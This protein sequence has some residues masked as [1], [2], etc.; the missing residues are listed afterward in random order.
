MDDYSA[1]ETIGFSAQLAAIYTE[2]SRYSSLFCRARFGLS[3]TEYE[4]LLCLWEAETPLGFNQLSDFLMLKTST[5]W[6]MVPPLI[7]RSLLAAE[8]SDED[9]RRARL[10]LTEKGRLLAE[11]CCRDLFAFTKGVAQESLPDVEYNHY[12]STG[13][14][15]N[16]DILRGHEAD[17]EL[18]RVPADGQGVEFTLFTRAILERWRTCVRK[19]CGLAFNEFRVLHALSEVPSL[20]IQDIS[21]RLLSPRS[22][23]SLSK[24]RLCEAHLAKEM[25]NPF[26][27]RSMLVGLT[28]RGQRTLDRALPALDAITI[29]AHNP[30][31]DEAVMI[32]RAWHSRMYYNLKRNHATLLESF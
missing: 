10:S 2:L 5:L 17:F 16:L 13:I 14:G 8:S 32:L 29:P 27:S 24:R 18:R 3:V 6:H 9:R 31:T 21:D 1:G 26:D 23:V 12:L 11:E 22:H 30:G 25:P 15:G 20:R 7:D 4:L 19:E 28:A